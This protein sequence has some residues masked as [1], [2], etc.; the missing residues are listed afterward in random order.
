MPDD[1]NWPRASAWLGGEHA[2]QPACRLAVL[3]A[4]LHLGSISPGQADLAPA[5]VRSVLRR[6]STYDLEF[7]RDLGQVAAADLGDLALADTRP[8]D[9]L[10]PIASAVRNALSGADA[11]VLLGGDN[12][13]TR[14]GCHG[15]SAGLERV[16]LLTLDAHLDLRDLKPELTNGNPVRA[17]LADGLP[18]EQIVQVGIQPFA[19]SRA[20]FQVA[21]EAG[22]RVIPAAEVRV[23]GIERAVEAALDSLDQQVDAI[24]VDL[25]LDV[26]D[27]AFAPATPGSRP[28]GLTPAEVR[29]AA[30]LCGAHPKVR[31]MDLVEMDPTKDVSEA[32]AFAAG[33]CLLSFAS[34]LLGRFTR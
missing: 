32:T 34:G 25:D 3:G 19:N 31:V 14:P 17:L 26:L 30:R 4:P 9:A 8:A 21:R 24:Y 28:G 33:I 23:L 6:L 29:S 11:L 20:Y 2:S 12:S 27:R 7:D 5:A 22:I 15:I 16:G 1:P 13:I 10:E 18:G